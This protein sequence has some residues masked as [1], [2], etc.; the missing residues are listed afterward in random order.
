[1]TPE[2]RA[3]VRAVTG[4]P[5]ISEYGARESGL[6]AY[7]CP[8]GK[9]HVLSPDVVIEVFRDGRPAPV[10]EVG[11]IITTQL[12]CRAQPLV[13]YAQGDLGR[14]TGAQ[15]D[16]GWPLPVLEL[17]NT[18]ITGLIALPDG[19]LCSSNL[20]GYIVRDHH[21]VHAFR[22]HQR[23]LTRF[24]V[25]LVVAPEFRAAV[26]AQVTQRCQRYL[27]P[28]T[29]LSF[30]F[31]DEIPPQPSGKRSQF[32]SDIA[33]DYHHF[34]LVPVSALANDEEPSTAS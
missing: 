21:A 8:L 33:G 30:Q 31:V 34:E 32:I 5:L 22:V 7:E 2:Q 14:L 23:S 19:R 25:M 1:V 28:Q 6:M 16:C 13:R 11:E 12:H 27:G 20:M 3:Q 18:R 24:D 10:G 4:A 17:E 9:L 26:Q 29:E 15:C